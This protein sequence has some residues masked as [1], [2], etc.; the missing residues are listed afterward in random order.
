VGGAEIKLNSPLLNRILDSYGLVVALVID[1]LIVGICFL[2]VSPGPVEAVAM[3]ALSLVVVLF[4]VRAWIKGNK[5]LWAMFAFV[6][7]F[8]DLSFVLVSTDVQSQ[9]TGPDTELVRLTTKQDEADRAV[10]DLQRQ[11]DEA[12]KRETMDQIFAQLETARGV[13]AEAKRDRDRRLNQTEHAKPPI[14][15]DAL[16]MAIPE[17][18]IEP[19]RIIPLVVF[20]ILF[21]GLQLTIISAATD[22]PTVRRREKISVSENDEVENWVWSNWAGKSG[23]IISFESFNKFWNAAGRGGFSEETYK[24]IKQAAIDS[25]VISPGDE[26]IIT[27]QAEAQRIIE[28]ALDK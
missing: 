25:G 5:V 23:R 17:A 15:A 1:I 20:G 21:S 26:I 16:F 27:D 24:K 7:F 22:A 18:A 6:A 28:T 10:S 3:G 11:Y 12:A 4:G 14:T 13:A 2:V 19:R 9:A 8:F